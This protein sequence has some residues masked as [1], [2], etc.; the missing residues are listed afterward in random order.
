VLLAGCAA[1]SAPPSREVP[2][3][4]VSTEG[5]TLRL[6]VQAGGAPCDGVRK[7]AVRETPSTVTVTVTTGAEPR[8]NCGPGVVGMIGTLPVDAKLKAPLGARRLIDG[9]P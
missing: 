5:R 6:T 4:L 2:F 8:A 7:V 1:G 3:T 9:A